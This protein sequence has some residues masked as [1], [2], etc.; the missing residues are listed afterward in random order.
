MNRSVD[1]RINSKI[2]EYF[3]KQLTIENAVAERLVTRIHKT[4]IEDLKQR[5]EQYLKETME[6]QERVYQLIINLGGKPTDTK[7]DLP[8]LKPSYKDTVAE[9]LQDKVKSLIIVDEERQEEKSAED[10]IERIKEDFTIAKATAI[11]YKMLLNIAQKRNI[12][13]ALSLLEQCFQEEEDM[14]NWIIN[15]VSTII[16]KLWPKIESALTN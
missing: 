14:S 8:I 2:T 4:P 7:A 3:I 12:Q 16:T 5:L 11:S 9:D 1:V 15:N 10:E 13:E 6:H